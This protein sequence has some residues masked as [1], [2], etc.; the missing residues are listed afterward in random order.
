MLEILLPAWLAGL[1][2]AFIT[3]PLGVFVVWRKMS[4][5]SDTISHSAI[6]GV[7]LGIWAEP[8]LLSNSY[9]S[10]IPFVANNIPYLFVI[11]VTLILGLILSYLENK[12][13]LALDTILGVIAHTA[14]SLGV[15]TI[16]LLNNVRVDLMGYLF[17]DL[18]AINYTDVVFLIIVV[19]LILLVLFRYWREFLS[20]TVHPDLAKIEGLNIAKLRTILMLL[21]ALVIALCMK[22]VGALVIASFLIIPSATARRFSK[23]PL[24]MILYSFVFTLVMLSLGLMLSANFDTPAGPSVVLSAGVVFALSLFKKQ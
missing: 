20:I 16:A 11:V 6:L 4:Y 24:Q 17:G 7:A 5:F 2:L 21:T 14:L 9:F 19:A 18:L 3:A 10:E 12:T 22:F 8:W 13:N 1:L 15:V 23:T